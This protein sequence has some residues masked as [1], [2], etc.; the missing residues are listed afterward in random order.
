MRHANLIALASST[1][2]LLA[3]CGGSSG[4]GSP[5]AASQ[6]TPPAPPA[7]TLVSGVLEAG[8]QGFLLGGRPVDLRGAT[9]TLDGQAIGSESL[10]PGMPITGTAREQPEGWRLERGEVRSEVRGPA[11]KVESEHLQVLGHEIHVG[12]DARVAEARPEG[13]FDPLKREELRRGDTLRVFGLAGAAGTLEATRVER[14]RRAEDPQ[15]PQEVESA[16]RLSGL[17]L[18]ASRF[19]LNAFTVDFSAAQVSGTLE[20]GASVQVRG[21]LSGLNIQARQVRVEDRAPSQASEFEVRGPLSGLDRNA[22]TFTVAGT[23][24]HFA[25]AVVTGTLMD[26]AW[27]QVR[28]SLANG[29]ATAAT[30]K[31]EDAVETEA[32][33]EGSIT[34]FDAA[35]RTFHLQGQLVRVTQATVYE[36]GKAR[37]SAEAFWGTSR[38]GAP[39]QVKGIAAGGSLVAS[40]VELK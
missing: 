33:P 23:L 11:E 9:I 1:L 34:G 37:L 32:R 40:K 25:A 16:G 36:Q 17:D 10:Q 8:A 27:V 5:P 24:I 12:E 38:E 2:L 26:G 3:A 31:V 14:H 21:L 13:G 4:S 18:A 15:P 28:G 6:P 19:N 30:V 35:G 7:A 22:Q 20:E 29:V 39:A